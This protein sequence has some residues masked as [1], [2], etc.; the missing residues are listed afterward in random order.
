MKGTITAIIPPKRQGDRMTG[1]FGFLRDADGAE[2]FF[3]AR[4][5]QGTTIEEL[6]TGMAVEFTALSLP[7]APASGS[8]TKNNG[9]RATGVTVAL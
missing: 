1:G 2:R 5:V 7:A 8:A 6:A 3:H 4:D 9:L